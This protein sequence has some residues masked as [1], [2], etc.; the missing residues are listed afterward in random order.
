MSSNRW[1]H[2]VS[3]ERGNSNFAYVSPPRVFN[4]KKYRRP[5][6]YERAYEE[7]MERESKYRNK[8]NVMDFD[9][10]VPY[11]LRRNN[12]IKL[13]NEHRKGIVYIYIY[14]YIHI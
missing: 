2:N 9:S 1:S 8:K 4:E 12:R 3:Y 13:H 11:Y 7:R 10:T 14:I 6:Q 5:P